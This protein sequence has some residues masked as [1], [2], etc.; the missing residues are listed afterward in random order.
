MARAREA[1]PDEEG[2]DRFADA[3]RQRGPADEDRGGDRPDHE[4]LLGADR[5]VA[6]EQLAPPVHR[7][8]EHEQEPDG[9]GDV[10]RDVSEALA[11]DEDG[12]DDRE[13]HRDE[14]VLEDERPSIG[15]ASSLAIQPRSMSDFVMTADDEM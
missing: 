1:H 12:R 4:Q 14:E 9:G 10:G 11:A 15:W 2:S 6:L 5:Q 3:E 7:E 8:H 13:I